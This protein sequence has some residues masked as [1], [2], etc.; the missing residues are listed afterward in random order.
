VTAVWVS[1]ANR[2]AEQPQIDPEPDGLFHFDEPQ[3]VRA[4]RR[5]EPHQPN[6]VMHALNDESIARRAQ[7]IPLGKTQGRQTENDRAV[8]GEPLPLADL[9]V[10]GPHVLGHMRACSGG[11]CSHWRLCRGCVAEVGRPEGVKS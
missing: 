2:I 7:H 11:A 6:P 3:A 8:C 1:A 9:W 10:S 4:R 5:W